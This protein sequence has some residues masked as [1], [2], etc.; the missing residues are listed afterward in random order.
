MWSHI[1]LRG[2]EMTNND[3]YHTLINEI[4]ALSLISTPERFY[5]SANFKISEVDF[6]LQYQDRDEGRAVLIYGDMGAL[7][8]R[9]RD[10]ALLA[11]MDI[12]FHMFSGVHSPVFSW[13]AQTSRVLLMGSVSLERASAEGVLLLMKSFADLANEWREHGFIGQVKT[14]GAP[15]EQPV[16]TAAKRESLSASGKFQ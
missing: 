10:A 14:A 2:R 9:N 8:T 12:N 16:A 13:N 6:T 3:P 11:L 5:E 1:A 15:A 4:C 7:P